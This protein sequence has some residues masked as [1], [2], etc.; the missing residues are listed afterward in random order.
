M[1]LDEG[2]IKFQLDHTPADSFHESHI[3]ELNQWRKWMYDLGLIGII[4]TPQGAVGYGNISVRTAEGFLISGSQTGH[5]ADLG[6]QH[7]ALV[8]AAF[9]E[10][11]RLVSRGPIK[12]SSE[13]LTHA[14]VYQ[15]DPAINWVLH[16][17]H[18]PIWLAAERLGIPQTSQDAAYGT[19]EMATE[20]TRIF[21][22]T[23][24]KEVRIFS[25]AGHEDGIVTFGET[26]ELAAGVM[27]KY[28]RSAENS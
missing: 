12:P 22:E 17:H 5:L 7:Y 24:V 11:N 10:E 25:M 21:V 14:V 2:V 19:P 3:T 18:K 4:D 15:Q 1:S 28:L 13:S 26:A 6:A 9:P 20:T 27:E 23:D 16:A 8:T